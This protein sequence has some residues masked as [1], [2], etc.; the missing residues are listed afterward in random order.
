MKLF[1][2]SSFIDFLLSYLKMNTQ[3]FLISFSLIVTNTIFELYESY[4]FSKEDSWNE[5]LHSLTNPL[6]CW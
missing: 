2:N 1:Q 6:N 3:N 4:Q 5:F